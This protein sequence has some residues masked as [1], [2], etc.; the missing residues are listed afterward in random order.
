MAKIIFK[1]VYSS[2]SY[3][4][5]SFYETHLGDLKVYLWAVCRF[6]DIGETVWK[7]RLPSIKIEKKAVVEDDLIEVVTYWEVIIYSPMY[8]DVDMMLIEKCGSAL[9]I[10]YW[11]I[12]F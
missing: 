11:D 5:E 9:K 3:W 8:V 4:G 2:K 7:F 12:P 6:M 1:P 10:P